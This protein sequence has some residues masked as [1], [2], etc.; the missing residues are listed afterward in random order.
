MTALSIHRHHPHH[1]HDPTVIACSRYRIGHHIKQELNGRMRSTPSV[2]MT[3]MPNPLLYVSLSRSGRSQLV[4]IRSAMIWYHVGDGRYQHVMDRYR[5]VERV[6]SSSCSCSCIG[7]RNCQT[8]T[9]RTRCVHLPSAHRHA[10]LIGTDW[11][12][13]LVGWSC[14]YRLK[15]LLNR[16]RARCGP[17]STPNIRTASSS[18]ATTCTRSILS[19]INQRYTP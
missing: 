13:L 18:R 2:P 10:V 9:S 17:S 12:V 19:S 5:R 14:W 3:R 15:M 1:H 7:A 4:L 11:L 16:E 6:T 8:H